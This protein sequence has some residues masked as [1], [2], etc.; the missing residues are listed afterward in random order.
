LRRHKTWQLKELLF[1]RHLHVRIGSKRLLVI[2]LWSRL[3]VENG[4]LHGHKLGLREHA[5]VGLSL[6][7]DVDGLRHVEALWHHGHL[8]L[9]EED[10][11]DS[12]RFHHLER[13]HLAT[14]HFLGGFYSLVGHLFAVRVKAGLWLAE[15]RRKA[16]RKNSPGVL[17]LHVG[18]HPE[19][20]HL[21]LCQVLLIIKGGLNFK[22]LLHLFLPHNGRESC[23]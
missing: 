20:I 23:R 2:E 8:L 1:H 7:K 16:I 19:W 14:H 12:H 6:S 9:R 13:H 5:K 17:N 3:S 10:R 15:L 21:V 4:C 22:F 18:G 11:R